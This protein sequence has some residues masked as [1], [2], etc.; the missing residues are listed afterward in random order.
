[1]TVD[2]AATSQE[3]MDHG[4]RGSIIGIGRIHTKSTGPRDGTGGMS[5]FTDIVFL[6]LRSNRFGSGV[7][8]DDVHCMSN[9]GNIAK[10][11]EEEVDE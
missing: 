6:P 1:M 4:R 7:G 11:K 3:W 10:D 9:S 8:D 5:R 2:T